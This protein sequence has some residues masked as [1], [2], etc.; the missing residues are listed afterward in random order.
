MGAKSAEYVGAA[1]SQLVFEQETV[2]PLL[3]N[4]LGHCAG[5]KITSVVQGGANSSNARK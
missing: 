1:T 5:E 2:K 3:P 4:A